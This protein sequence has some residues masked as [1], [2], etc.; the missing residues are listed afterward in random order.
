[1]AP[2]GNDAPPPTRASPDSGRTPPLPR[3]VARDERLSRRA[4][5]FLAEQW[6]NV[7]TWTFTVASIW[8]AT[9]LCP[10]V[11]GRDALYAIVAELR[12]VGYVEPVDL[13]TPDE[14]GRWRAEVG[15]RYRINRA[16]APS[17]GDGF[18]HVPWAVVRDRRLSY[19]A[20]GLL[21]ER[22]ADGVTVRGTTVTVHRGG[23]A[24]LA[25]PRR[26]DGAKAVPPVLAELLRAGYA[27]QADRVRGDDGRLQRAG[28]IVF[29]SEPILAGTFSFVPQPT[30]AVP[31]PV[32]A[33][34]SPV[35]NPTTPEPGPTCENT[36]SPQNAP[37]SPEPGTHSQETCPTCGNAASPQVTTRTPFPGTKGE[38]LQGSLEREEELGVRSVR[39]AQVPDARESAPPLRG[40]QDHDQAQGRGQRTLRD[41]GPVHTRRRPSRPAATRAAWTTLGRLPRAYRDGAPGWVR[42][43][44]ARRLDR[45]MTGGA[46]AKGQTVPGG[47]TADAIVATAHRVAGERPINAD[48]IAA[49]A[50]VHA[51]LQADL[52]AG[53]VCGTCGTQR[54]TP[55]GRCPRCDDQ[56]PLTEAEQQQLA[57]IWARLQPDDPPAPQPAD[58]TW[59]PP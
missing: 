6:S 17:T 13:A 10:E 57:A 54:W 24:A 52:A 15:S 30:V 22:L 56:R 41:G 58:T 59:R 20:R 19:R 5:G 4:R 48:H 29:R 11:E 26:G 33:P 51:R 47:L 28:A 40:N 50:A 27:A 46:T 9:R 25:G 7:T 43:E 44:M 12:D 55:H 36:T 49:L 35:E 34:P 38:H 16:V 3:S 18:V 32:P 14:T 31:E 1:M 42:R 2:R 53:D 45:M 39:S 37:T 21:V 23:P 8:A